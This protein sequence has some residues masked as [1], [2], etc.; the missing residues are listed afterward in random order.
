MRKT[1]DKN[2]KY[3]FCPFILDGKMYR[4]NILYRELV[5]KYRELF[6][7]YIHLL[8]RLDNINSN[9]R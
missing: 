8:D 2:T 7:K 5:D 9:G 3:Y 6:E 4:E 1:V